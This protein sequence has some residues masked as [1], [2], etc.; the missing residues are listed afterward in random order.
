[1]KQETLAIH[2]AYESD[3]F[4]SMAVPIYQTTAYDF[5]SAETAAD[6]FALKE[7]GMIYA[8]L[9]NPT[10]DIFEKR[11]SAVEGGEASWLPQVDT[12]QFCCYIKCAKVET[13]S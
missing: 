6:R 2:Y 4:G 3:K 5:G 12:R 13:I 11:I 7:I 9:T 8:R 1:M 10:T